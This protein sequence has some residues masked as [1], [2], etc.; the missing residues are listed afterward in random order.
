MAELMDAPAQPAQTDTPTE[1]HSWH[2]D[3]HAEL[4]KSKGWDGADAALKS[5]SELEKFKGA[6]EHL[7][8]PKDDDVDGWNKVYNMIGRPDTPDKYEFTND[9][10]VEISDELMNGFKAFAHKAGYNQKQLS[11]AIQ[12]QLEAVKASETLFA[13]QRQER[14][15]GHVSA[16]KQ[17]W[18]DEYE[19]TVTKIDATAEKLGV[20]AFLDEMGISKEPEIVN[21]LLTIANSDSE[22][23]LRADGL[24]APV[25]KDLPEQLKDIMASEAFQNKFHVDH[26][27]V[28][29][30]YMELNHK[31]ANS[32]QGRAPRK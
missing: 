18:Q 11:G 6:G 13:Q 32:G 20:K 12:F 9:T 8:I 15:D 28:M 25:A 14:T 19:P 24:P 16:M 7:L 31:I 5:Y 2:G 27:K 29:A 21:M 17:K 22:G 3:E 10:G 23:E 1:T 26:K 4:V 30:S